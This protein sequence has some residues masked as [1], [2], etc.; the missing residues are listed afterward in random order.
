MVEEKRLLGLAIN[1]CRSRDGD[2]ST[3]LPLRSRQF[4]RAGKLDDGHPCRALAVAGNGFH[5]RSPV[6]G[7]G[8]SRLSGANCRDE[9]VARTRSWCRTRGRHRA[10]M[11]RRLRDVLSRRSPSP[12]DTLEN[13]AAR[14]GEATPEPK[15]QCNRNIGHSRSSATGG[16]CGKRRTR[17][18]NKSPSDFAPVTDC[19]GR[20]PTFASGCARCCSPLDTQSRCDDAVLGHR[21]LDEIE[22]A[23]G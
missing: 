9:R 11:A 6:L 14:R 4:P 18:G 16:R 5:S 20:E 19:I 13:T 7:D 2:G 12:L 15:N 23:M 3:S 10:G 17:E 1:L 22:T 8:S 21:R